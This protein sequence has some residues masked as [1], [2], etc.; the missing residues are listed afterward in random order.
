MITARSKLLPAGLLAGRGGLMRGGR[1]RSFALHFFKDEMHLCVPEGNI[2]RAIHSFKKG[3]R[4]LIEMFATETGTYR[5]SH[6]IFLIYKKN[7]GSSTV[8]LE[9]EKI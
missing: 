9:S 5:L 6:K 7:Y 1:I 8:P 2:R 3:V 4:I